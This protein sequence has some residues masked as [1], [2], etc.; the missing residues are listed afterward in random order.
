MVTGQATGTHSSI[1]FLTG[2]VAARDGETSDCSL[3]LRE[4][5]DGFERGCVNSRAAAGL[6]VG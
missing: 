4:A 2:V 3:P 6:R 1:R 5:R